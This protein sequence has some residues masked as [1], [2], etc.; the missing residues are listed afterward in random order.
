MEHTRWGLLIVSYLFLG[1]MSAGLLFISASTVHTHVSHIYE[2][3][4]VST[5]AGLAMFAMEH[6]LI[7]PGEAGAATP[8]IT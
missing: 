7:R 5:R 1:G 4:E 8:R 2:K 6:D 3:A